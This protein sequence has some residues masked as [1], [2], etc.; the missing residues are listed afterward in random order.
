MA[1][2][3]RVIDP[4]PLA[5]PQRLGEVAR[6]DLDLVTRARNLWMIGRITR[7]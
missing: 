7:T 2:D 4:E 3:R 1:T 6:R 5:Q